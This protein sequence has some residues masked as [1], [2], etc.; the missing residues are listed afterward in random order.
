MHVSTF[1][2][3]I[4]KNFKSSE[5]CSLIHGSIS[6][7]VTYNFVSHISYIRLHSHM[8]NDSLNSYTIKIQM[9]FNKIQF[10]LC[11]N[12]AFCILVQLLVSYLQFIF[13]KK[14]STYFN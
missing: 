14:P 6:S 3:Q 12:S 8:V 7:I 2:F 11:F 4:G 9:Y 10:I 13:F 5:M 1:Y